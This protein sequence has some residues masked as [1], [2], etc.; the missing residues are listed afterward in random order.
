MRLPERLLPE[1]ITRDLTI[2]HSSRNGSKPDL[3]VLHTTEGVMSLH[4]RSEFWDS[5]F[6]TSRASS[7]HVGVGHRSKGQAGKSAR[8]V[9][10]DDKAWTQ[11][12]LNPRALSIEI[13][14]FAST[15]RGTWPDETVKEVARWIAHWSIVEGIPI[16]RALTAFGGVQRSGVAS[17]SQL[18]AAGGGHS[19]PGTFPIGRAI[20]LARKIKR[21]R[22]AR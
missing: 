8:Y 16:R 12:M 9:L 5:T 10:D 19:D 21:A 17:H 1:V 2:S 14:G 13:E 20:R 18:G 6:G 15:P 3:I 4:D 11:F 7:S 22:K